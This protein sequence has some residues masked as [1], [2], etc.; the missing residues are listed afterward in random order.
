M[1]CTR[2]IN[3]FSS[4][5]YFFCWP[6][7]LSVRRKIRQM[8]LRERRRQKCS[9]CQIF[10]F[11]ESSKSRQRILLAFGL[12]CNVC[13]DQATTARSCYFG[14]FNTNFEL[15]RVHL[16]YM[17]WSGSSYA[18]NLPKVNR[19]KIMVASPF[20]ALSSYLQNVERILASCCHLYINC[21]AILLFI[22]TCSKLAFKTVVQYCLHCD[23][24]HV[25][26]F[27]CV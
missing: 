4:Y 25:S 16:C 11:D 15:T 10:H 1:L 7:F 17:F 26:F 18:K 3:F 2:Q 5:I 23:A 12:V 8:Q 9:N 24:E 20:A 19:K 27:Q 14:F 6:F 21:L 22:E 13:N